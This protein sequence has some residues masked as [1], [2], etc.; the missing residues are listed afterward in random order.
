M[1][2]QNTTI[3]IVLGLLIGL[4]LWLITI[5]ISFLFSF[6]SEDVFFQTFAHDL[7]GLG[8]VF[9]LVV[10]FEIWGLIPHLPSN[11]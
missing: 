4:I 11:D 7:G 3:R 1:S 5:A 10:V 8:L 6:L 9:S 2:T